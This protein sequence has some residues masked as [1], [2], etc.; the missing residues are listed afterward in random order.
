MLDCLISSG[1]VTQHLL[2][3]ES[4]GAFL[5]LLTLWYP[6]PSKDRPVIKFQLTLP[7]IPVSICWFFQ[8]FPVLTSFICPTNFLYFFL[9]KCWYLAGLWLLMICPYF[10]LCFE[11]IHCNQ[12]CCKYCLWVCYLILCAGSRRF[13]I[14]LLSLPCVLRIPILIILNMRKFDFFMLKTHGITS[15]NIAEINL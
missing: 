5:H 6:S 13:K 8:G 14:R 12:I 7:L 10:T 9:L 3:T 2:L 1:T 15:D 11:E 4:K